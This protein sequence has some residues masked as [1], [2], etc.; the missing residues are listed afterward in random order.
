MIHRGSWGVLAAGMV[1]GGCASPAEDPAVLARVGQ[2]RITAPMLKAFEARQPAPGDG[3]V[4]HRANL[5]TLVDREIL[6]LE[7]RA[8]GLEEDAQVLKK[9]DKRETRELAEQM[10]RAQVLDKISI[11]PGEVEQLY[12]KGGWDQQVLTQEIF[13]ADAQQARE[14]TALLKAGKDFSEVAYAHSVDRLFKTPAGGPQQFAYS[15]G[16]APRAVVEA[17][18]KLPVGGVTQPIFVRDGYV[19]AKVTGH[20]KVG[21]EEVREKIHKVAYQARKK[22]LKYAYLKA[23]GQEFNLQLNPQGMEVVLGVLK[24]EDSELSEAQKRLPVYTYEAQELNVEEVLEVTLPVRDEW[25]EVTQQKVAE[26]LVNTVFPLKVMAQDARQKG[27]DR[28]EEFQR[29][30]QREIENLMISRLRALALEKVDL[31]QRDLEAFYEAHKQTFR[32]PA[33]ARVQEILVEDPDQARAIVEQLG[34]G[35][36]MAAL[37]RAR[38][39]RKNAEDGI[40]TVYGLQAAIYGEEWMK[41]VMNVPLGQVQGPLKA[42][43]GY[44]VF[45]VLDRQPE[46]FY[47]LDQQGVLRAVRQGVTEE[48]Q[49]RAFNEYLEDLKKRYAGQVEI[50]EKHL[51]SLEETA[52][53][54][55]V[56][57]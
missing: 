53:P 2:V 25:P 15:P 40:L 10:M 4:D 16:D 55:Q 20:R 57:A 8:R 31:T 34:R 49:R 19:I 33:E 27:M 47:G 46:R 13:V 43:G 18:A 3:R 36:D 28:R 17:V 11:G 9:L 54:K 48:K 35:A 23:L 26:E 51:E 12:A 56:G 45:K 38:S 29:W 24:G 7:T 32:T 22:D 39:I 6:L 52:A 30:R 44:S 37:A 5:Q 42:K 21:I 1:L 14:V 41:A 50:Y